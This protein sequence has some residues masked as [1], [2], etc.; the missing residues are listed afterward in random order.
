MAWSRLAPRCLPVGPGP[1]VRQ[2][3]R[4]Q[5]G[6]VRGVGH[7][8]DVQQRV[9]GQFAV[10]AQ[11][12]QVGGGPQRRVGDGLE[13]Q[14]ADVAQVDRAPGTSH[15]ASRPNSSAIRVARRGWQRL[16]RGDRRASA[17]LCSP[18]LRV[19]ERRRQRE[20]RLAVL[21][22]GDPP[23]GERPA[24]P[25]PVH[26]VDDRHGGVARPDEVGVQRV[27]RP[28]V[29]HRAARRHQRLAG[30]L[31]AE[32]PLPPLVLRAAAAED[33]RARSAPGRAGPPRR[34]SAWLI[35]P[36]PPS[37][38]VPR[39]HNAITAAPYRS[40]LAWPT[41]GMAA[42]AARLPGRASAIRASAA[43]EKITN[44]GTD[45]SLAA[46]RRHSRS[47]RNSGLPGSLRLPDPVGRPR[48]PYRAGPRCPGRPRRRA[49]AP[50]TARAQ[51]CRACAGHRGTGTACGRPGR[52]AAGQRPGQVQPLP[53]PGDPDVQQPPLLL[54]R[55]GGLRV[56]DRQHAVGQAGQEHRVPLQALGGVQRGERDASTRGACPL[57]R[58]PRLQLGH[59]P[60]A[61]RR[62]GPAKK[63][64]ASWASACSDSQRSRAW[65]RP[66]GGSAVRP[67]PARTAG[68]ARGSSP[69]RTRTS[70]PRAAG[71]RPAT[72]GRSKNRSAPRTWNG[73]P[74]SAS[75][76]S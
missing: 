31:A 27:H 14:R 8:A 11:P 55:L 52:P 56:D 20:D 6:H 62:R 43:S 19:V 67:R 65:P 49:P 75:A 48:G 47:C 57:A 22:R 36:H 17:A 70:R 25:D 68:P 32:H 16:G 66:P 29:R 7:Q 4:V 35:G 42:R 38:P 15:P 28:V 64:S 10:G 39:A 34:R 59:G 21:H 53:G 23:G 50:G 2:Q 51:A 63:S 46:S 54:H 44:A 24:V 12:D 60:A 33:V 76:C 71:P 5:Q 72:S 61:R 3:H 41:P 1:A 69:A 30:H 37:L 74:A 9:V 13:R 40:S 26:H 73:T 45:C 58:G 18:R